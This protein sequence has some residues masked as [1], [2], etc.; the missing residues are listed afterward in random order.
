ME[1]DKKIRGKGLRSG[2]S[3]FN[4]CSETICSLIMKCMES[5]SL[6]TVKEKVDS[7]F[8]E[9]LFLPAFQTG[10]VKK[11]QGSGLVISW[12]NLRSLL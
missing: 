1:K 10:V 3:S 12:H 4:L 9:V 5:C 11:L 6:F 7:A 8:S 2:K